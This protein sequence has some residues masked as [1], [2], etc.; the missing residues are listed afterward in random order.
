MPIQGQGKAVTVR[1]L[2]R[3]V[4]AVFFYLISVS[5]I[6]AVAAVF[7]SWLYHHRCL[8]LQLRQLRENPGRVVFWSMVFLV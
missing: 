7:L 4:G 3:V 6:A 5:L 2:A 8:L 1:G